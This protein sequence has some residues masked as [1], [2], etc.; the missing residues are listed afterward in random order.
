MLSNTKAELK[1]SVVKKNVY[2]NSLI[3]NGDTLLMKLS[4]A[5]N[6]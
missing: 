4:I 1:Q 6:Y 3:G 5:M 2:N